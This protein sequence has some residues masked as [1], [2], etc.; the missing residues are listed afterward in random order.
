MLA[1][2]VRP[3]ICARDWIMEPA[4]RNATPAVTA[5]MAL[6]GS[7]VW[8]RFSSSAIIS[9]VVTAKIEA[10]SAISIWVRKPA[11]RFFTSRSMPI[12]PP[13]KR[14]AIRRKKIC[15]SGMAVRAKKKSQLP[16]NNFPF[17]G[18]AIPLRF[19]ARAQSPLRAGLPDR[20]APGSRRGAFL[21]DITHLAPFLFAWGRTRIK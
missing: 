2:V 6:M 5:S 18:P 3:E 14:A 4:A 9:S 19:S 21:F 7:A 16:M 20:A 1:P 11:G 17:F 12:A 15:H 10:A 8:P 13:R